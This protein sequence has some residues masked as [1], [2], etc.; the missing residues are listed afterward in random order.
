VALPIAWSLTQR[1]TP[2]LVARA[3]PLQEPLTPTSGVLIVAVITTILTGVLMGAL[4]AYRAIAVR[5]DEVLRGGRAVIRGMGWA[6]RGVIVT[7]VALAMILVTGAGLFVATL[8]NLYA[9]DSAVRTKPILWTRLGAKPG[10]RSNPTDSDIRALVDRLSTVPGVDAAALSFY[11]PAY[12]GFPGVLT[13]TTIAVP[14]A[15]QNGSTATG[16]TESVTPGF[17]DLAGIARTGG[18]DFTWTDNPNTPAVAII[19]ES[20]AGQLFPAGDAIDHEVQTTVAGAVSRLLVVGVVANAPIGRIDEPNLPVVFRPMMQNL[21]QAVVPIAHVRV[22]GDLSLARDGYV[23]AVN[24]LGRNVVRALF[25]MDEWVDGAL[26]QQRLVANVATSAALIAVLLAAI[27]VFCVLA[28]SVTARVREIG[29]RMSL[30]ATGSAI[31]QVVVREGLIVV[32]IGVVLGIP[33]AIAVARLV[34][35]QLYGIGS[36]DPVMVTAA[37]LIF[38]GTAGLAAWLPARRASQ[39]RPMD[40]L[41]QD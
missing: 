12:L 6:G 9:N 5:T 41:R 8:A 31:A 30:G 26:L 27:G 15:G 24:A 33:L 21:S 10:V 25:T 40:A 39:I 16:L 32:T 38:L 14:S 37:A 36:A 20:L 17:F 34:R 11:Y 2:L 29:I 13:S 22:D 23:D 18:R 19:S 7:Q 1:V 4:P 3:L 28:Y 35:A